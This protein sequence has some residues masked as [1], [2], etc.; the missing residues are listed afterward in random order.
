VCK[1]QLVLQNGFAVDQRL[2]FIGQ[3]AEGLSQSLGELWAIH[4]MGADDGMV[5]GFVFSRGSMK[6]K[7]QLTSW[8]NSASGLVLEKEQEGE[9]VSFF[10]LK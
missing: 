1:A 9:S 4:P 5:G 8:A 2:D 10:G 7:R 3:R 6:S